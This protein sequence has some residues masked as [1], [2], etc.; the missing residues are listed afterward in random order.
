MK[1]FQN[2][3]VSENANEKKSPFSIYEGEYV[4]R[5]M[6]DNPPCGIWLADIDKAICKKLSTYLV[7]SSELLYRA[8][9]NEGYTYEKKDIQFHL[10]KLARS[11]YVQ[12]LGFESRSGYAAGKA[13]ILAGRGIGLL[14][15][16]GIRCRMGG[17]LAEQSHV[18]I[19][20]ILAA[21]QVLIAGRYDNVHVAGVVL[22]EAK[23]EQEKSA[24]IFR[25]SATCF[26]SEGKAHQFVEVI[27]RTPTAEADLLDK[28]ERV[29]QVMK[30]KKHANIKIGENV[31]VLLVAEDHAHMDEI[32]ALT[33]KISK[34]LNLLFTYDYAAYA[35]PN[36]FLYTNQTKPKGFFNALAACL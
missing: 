30:R 1:K 28:L 13:Y 32:A 35:T 31:S 5:Y 21:N 29:I 16:M 2:F 15:S 34:K 12:K 19:K 18:G 7:L 33:R 22:I 27:R 25:P 36:D 24:Y 9:A 4:R 6:L 3:I 17:F 14:H 20:R 8:F 10:T 26:D 23:H 11:G